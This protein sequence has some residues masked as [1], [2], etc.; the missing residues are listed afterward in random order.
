MFK[1]NEYIL[2]ILIGV[3]LVNKSCV[4]HYKQ[5]TKC[6]EISKNIEKEWDKDVIHALCTTGKKQGCNM[7]KHDCHMD[8]K[9]KVFR[10]IL[11]ILVLLMITYVI[12][13]K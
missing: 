5:K 11:V 8:K 12:F 6:A 7:K 2:F 13:N 1:S 9:D 3:Y 10:D 4:E